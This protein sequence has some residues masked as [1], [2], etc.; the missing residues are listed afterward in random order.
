MDKEGVEMLLSRRNGETAE[1]KFREID[2]RVYAQ[3]S[4]ISAQNTAIAALLS[5]VEAL[6]KINLGLLAMRGTG[7]SE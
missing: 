7:P 2:A 3:A 5:R 4:N 1:Q 6:E